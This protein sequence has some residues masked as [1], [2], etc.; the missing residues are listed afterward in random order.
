MVWYVGWVIRVGR[1]EVPQR[2]SL[3]AVA[4]GNN[5]TRNQVLLDTRSE[6]DAAPQ[7]SFSFSNALVYVNITTLPDTIGFI[8]TSIGEDG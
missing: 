8:E 4:P 3:Q 1:G 6:A 2:T 7:L 5:R